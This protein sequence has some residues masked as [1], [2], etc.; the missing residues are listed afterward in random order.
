MTK[1]DGGEPSRWLKRAK[2]GP[3][4]LWQ[5]PPQG[6]QVECLWWLWWHRRP[7]QRGFMM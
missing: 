6:C 5:K 2:Q 3:L 7:D 4:L 1:G